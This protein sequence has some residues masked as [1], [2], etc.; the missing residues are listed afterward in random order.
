[1]EWGV[2]MQGEGTGVFGDPYEGLYVKISI[3]KSR[4]KGRNDL[5]LKIQRW[6]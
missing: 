4:S 5:K 3:L 2:Y 1:M 6:F